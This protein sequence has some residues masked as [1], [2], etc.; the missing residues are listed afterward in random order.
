MDSEYLLRISWA[1]F[2]HHCIMAEERPFGASPGWHGLISGRTT[3]D[4]SFDV[5]LAGLEFCEDGA[6]GSAYTIGDD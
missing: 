2:C 4:D 3:D 5:R 6:S 1:E